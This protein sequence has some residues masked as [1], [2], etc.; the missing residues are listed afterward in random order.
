MKSNLKSEG[1]ALAACA[2]LVPSHSS[3]DKFNSLVTPRL[4]AMDDAD[5]LEK[6]FEEDECHGIAMG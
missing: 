6:F 4:G 3:S 5:A 1:A 2:P